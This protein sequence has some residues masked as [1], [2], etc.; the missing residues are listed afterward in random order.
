MK[1]LK[2]KLEELSI[3][4][5]NANLTNFIESLSAEQVGNY[6]YLIE[7]KKRE[8]IAES[9]NKIILLSSEIKELEE[10]K[11]LN[12]SSNIKLNWLK[13]DIIEIE[14]KRKNCL[15]YW[16]KIEERLKLKQKEHKMQRLKRLQETSK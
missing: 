6:L 15:S 12:G 7:T 2:R 13:D 3:N 5:N 1:K 16:K 4:Y 14:K 11:H 8:I 9:F 10:K